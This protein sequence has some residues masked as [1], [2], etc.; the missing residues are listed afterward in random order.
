MQDLLS[1]AIHALKK[2]L[3]EAEWWALVQPEFQA[4]ITHIIE[5]LKECGVSF[6]NAYINAYIFSHSIRR[7]RKLNIE[8]S[9]HVGLFGKQLSEECYQSAILP[10][11][12]LLQVNDWTLPNEAD[13]QAC[14]YV[15]QQIET[16]ELLGFI[17]ENKSVG[18]GLKNL[19]S[20][21]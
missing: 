19:I 14:M 4:S 21:S 1:S 18:S 12:M 17:G 7:V 2:R 15:C 8:P 5:N 3:T 11:K 20:D 6:K 9:I 13:V 10:T 16:F